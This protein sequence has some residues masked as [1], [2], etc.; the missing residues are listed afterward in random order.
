M[1]KIFGFAFLTYFVKNEPWIYSKA[2]SSP[3]TYYC[4]EILNS[5]IKSIMN[6]YIWELMDLIFKTKLLDYKWIFKRKMKAD[7]IIDK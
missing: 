4:K 3:K 7:D 1:T 6:N 2:M 5:K